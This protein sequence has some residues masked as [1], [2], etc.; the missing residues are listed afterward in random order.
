MEASM[1]RAAVVLVGFAIIL[2]GCGSSDNESETTPPAPKSTETRSASETAAALEGTW[3]TDPLTVANMKE[4]L[5]EARLAR[6]IGGFKR[7][8][9]ISDAPTALVLDIH[10]GRWDLYGQPEGGAREEIDYDAQ[11]E[12]DGETVVV[13]HEGD[14]NTYRWSVNDDVLSLTWLK[15]TYEPYEGIPEEVFQ[16]ALYMTEDFHRTP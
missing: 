15:T 14:S 6:S 16:R 11:Y 8:A 12:V 5:R 10:D 13:S 7:N 4:T 1:G 9:P 3:R 2:G